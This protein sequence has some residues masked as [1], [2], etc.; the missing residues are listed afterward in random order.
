MTGSSGSSEGNGSKQTVVIVELPGGRDFV[1]PSPRADMVSWQT[2]ERV[3][4]MGSR[5]RVVSRT[6]G[7]S[8]VLTLQLAPAG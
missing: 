8:D 5:W 1:W 6:N 4:Y 7:S 2:G 3:T